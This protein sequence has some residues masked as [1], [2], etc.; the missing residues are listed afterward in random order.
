MIYD[1]EFP[2]G[3][4]KEYAANVIADNM[5][6]RTDAE[7]FSTALF[8]GIVDFK[9]DETAIPKSERFVYSSKNNRRRLR[10]TTKGWNLQVPWKDGS[11][12]WIPLRT[13]KESNPVDVAEFAIAKGIQD[14]P[15]FAWW[16]PYTV[17]KSDTL[18]SKLKARVRKTTHK[19]GIVVPNH[20]EHAYAIDAKNKDTFWQDMVWSQLISYLFFMM[21]PGVDN[22]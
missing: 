22:N 7:G 14:E 16:V 21:G 2:D 9:K 13:L 8:D 1:L 6:S 17:K 12:T 19:Y 3:Q 20:V 4:I 10:Q 11:E 18:I 5:V 15:A